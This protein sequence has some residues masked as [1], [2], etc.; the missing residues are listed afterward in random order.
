V[1][2]DPWE[3]KV[4][5][6]AQD[7]S[8]FAPPEVFDWLYYAFIRGA[9]WQA[10]QMAGALDEAAGALEPLAPDDPT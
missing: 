10:A 3:A 2:T 5:A 6:A 4:R 9:R 8:R 1:E 7:D